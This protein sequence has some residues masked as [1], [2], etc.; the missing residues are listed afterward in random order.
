MIFLDD[1]VNYI[2]L[3][4]ISAISGFIVLTAI[5]VTIIFV[6]KKKMNQ[7]NISYERIEQTDEI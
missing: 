1:S 5:I 2:P 4:V 7:T 6:V 3:I